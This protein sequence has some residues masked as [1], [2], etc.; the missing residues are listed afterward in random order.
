MQYLLAPRGRQGLTYGQCFLVYIAMFLLVFAQAWTG[1]RVISPSR[2]GVLFGVDAPSDGHYKE[3][4]KFSDY[5][6]SHVAEGKAFL[7]GKRSGW[8]TTWTPYNELG[9]PT[10][11]LSDL[12]PAYLPNWIFSRLTADA[13]VYVTLIASLAVFLAGAFAFLLARE[14][15]LSPAAALVAALAMG[16]SPALIYW[17][18]FPMFAA[19]YGWTLAALFGLVRYVR[20]RD[21]LGWSVVAFSIYSLAMSAYP[22]MIVYHAYLAAGFLVYLYLKS[23]DFPRSTK[24]RAL[25]LAGLASA[26]L[27]GCLAALPAVWDTWASTTQSARM[28]PGVVFLRANIPPMSSA[29]D[30][31]RF[32]AYWTFPQVMGDP[33]A[34]D[35][36][37]L[38]NGRSLAPFIVFLIC[39]S[40]WRRVWGWWAAVLALVLADA[41]PP[42]FAFAV[43]HLGL[44]LSRSVP[45]VHAIVPLAMI[46]AVSM[47]AFTTRG[48]SSPEALAMERHARTRRLW[49]AVVLYGLLL[50]NAVAVS[51]HL[52]GGIDRSALLLFA[53]YAP[54]LWAALR[55]RQ[56]M[57]FVVVVAI[58]LCVFDRGLLLV[59]PRADIV[60]SA[61][62][63]AQ[64]QLLTDDGSRYAM[65][66]S[67]KD[68]MPA[69]VN[70]QASL[71]SIHTYD[72]LSPL[73]Y[74]DLIRRLGG[75]N[76]DYGRM[77]RAIDPGHI[78][79][80]DFMLA[81]VSALVTKV[82]LD[83][84]RVALQGS[85][86]GLLVYRVL[87]LW[88]AYMRVP[89][90]RVTT[91]GG[92]VWL[93]DEGAVEKNAAKLQKDRG[94]ILVLALTA[95]SAQ[96]SLFVLSQGYNALWHAEVRLSG[97]WVAARTVPVN[98]AFEG[99]VLP[100]GAGAVRLRFLPWVRWA[101]VAHAGFC[102]LALVLLV[103]GY[104][105][106]RRRE[107]MGWKDRST[108]DG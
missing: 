67:A 76:I 94:D 12:S 21:L 8:I 33:I 3:N 50:T 66:T 29:W 99:V 15:A 14:L 56:V 93:D 87:D 25:L 98:G 107:A 36:S 6:M 65:L 79:S 102:A 7:E 100:P 91:E 59:Q 80:V 71:R 51:I 2:Q 86:N 73:R 32:V 30:W 42:F 95:P 75:E 108:L 34:A 52:Q 9:R 31:G 38:F 46:A 55:W 57:L 83:S 103:T 1:G 39:A 41:W 17:A 96:Q 70:A 81:N 77:N 89:M 49:I 13:F 47:D 101:W 19:A 10:A 62:I 61:T 60:Q 63:T 23:P 43:E 82:P 16:V 22:V 40:P 58:H 11:H 64:L 74:Q 24:G 5:S 28:H 78:T 85:F 45:S 84:P 4:Y 27:L 90:N 53:A 44:G 48:D 18:P 35:F 88:G 104:G 72:S 37:P 26:S 54:V 20:H 105:R 106:L 69:N 68:F 97:R 92:G